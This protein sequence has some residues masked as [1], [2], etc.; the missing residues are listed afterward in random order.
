MKELT[1]GDAP[2]LDAEAEQ[3]E[4]LRRVAGCRYGSDVICG[5]WE[6]NPERCGRCEFNPH[7][8]R[9]TEA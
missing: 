6:K 4:V 2:L 7:I 3:M 1:K 9:S 8:V 5:L